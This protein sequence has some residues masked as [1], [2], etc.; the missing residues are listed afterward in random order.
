MATGVNV[1]MGVS[2]VSEFKRHMKDVQNSAKTLDAALA[3][4]EKQFKATGD[5]EAYMATKS[6]LLQTKIE[7]QKSI[8]SDAET[9]LK[10]MTDNGVDKASKAFQDMQQQLLK[11]KGELVDAETAMANIS[12]SADT[13]SVNAGNMSRELQQI[14]QGVNYQNITDGLDKITNGLGN[15]IKR[16]WQAGEA[17]VNA[18]LGAGSWADELKTTA[19]KYSTPEWTITP[20]ELQRMRKTSAIIDTDVESIISARK[21]LLKGLGGEDKDVFGFLHDKNIATE[22]RKAEDVF[23]DVGE[24][25]MAMT[26][27]ADQEAAAQKAFGKSWADLKPLF[28][29]G[30]DAYEEMNQSW[31]VVSDEQVDNLG[32]MDDA[33]Q[34]MQGE[35]ETFQMQVLEALSGPMKESMD[36]ISGLL[37]ELNEY[38]QTPQGK[39]MLKQMG[40][41]VSS[42]ISDL[43]EINPE[44]V[45]N[46]LKDIIDGITE[47]LKW[48]KDNSG[49]VKGALIAIGG[50]FL[51]LKLLSAGATIMKLVNALTGL[52][53]SEAA[54]AGAAIGSSWA[55]SFASAALKAAPW[56]VGLATLL[57][58]SAGSDKI[59]D[60]TLVDQNGNLTREAKTY[61]YE[62]DED[63]N[64]YG[65]MIEDLWNGPSTATGN[66]EAGGAR[67]RRWISNQNALEELQNAADKMDEAADSLMGNDGGTGSSG[68]AQDGN[69]N[70][71]TGL[72]GIIGAALKGWKI[73][74][75]GELVAALVA[76]QVNEIIGLGILNQ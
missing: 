39:E 8:I 48:I 12:D 35:W 3:L 23:W 40:D 4:N 62:L 76:P 61:G 29:A 59:G 16:A 33:Y 69:G 9:A 30:R 37:K 49:L 74:M 10:Q 44:D 53:A 22:G 27:D 66:E 72:P 11:A 75:D 18:T 65:Y 32:K 24:A 19:E 46:G 54:T 71:L 2:G 51:A 47:S 28:N 42:L 36:A 43:T 5:A 21:K 70:V 15:I 64:P 68:S 1:K 67:N 50:G 31:S 13:A 73:V 25:I 45:V 63:G 52:G 14:G 17:L 55:R 60:N 58:P 57:T 26:D 6:E 56:L 7:Q 38:L 20:E 41:T 34:K